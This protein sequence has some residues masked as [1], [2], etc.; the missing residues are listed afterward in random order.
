L[1]IRFDNQKLRTSSAQ[2]K[3]PCLI[4]LEF[5]EAR[6][7]SGMMGNFNVDLLAA[8]YNSALADVGVELRI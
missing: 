5:L 3:I 4:F 7:A 1:L 2:S 6:A 8:Y